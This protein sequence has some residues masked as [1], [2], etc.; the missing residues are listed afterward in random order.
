MQIDTITHHLPLIT[1]HVF[2]GGFYVL[3]CFCLTFS[4]IGLV[5]ISKYTRG[6]KHPALSHLKDIVFILFELYGVQAC[7]HVLAVQANSLISSKVDTVGSATFDS[8][9]HITHIY[10]PNL[11]S[12]LD[13][14]IFSI[15]GCTVVILVL[16]VHILE[17]YWT[18]V[19]E[20]RTSPFGGLVGSKVR[21]GCAAIWNGV[22][23]LRLGF[24]PSS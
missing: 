6:D 19:N 1:D 10:L 13:E 21:A 24:K 12:I 9:H 3:M 11:F 23:R 7:W 2:D 14:K 22:R 15:I 17:L 8:N 20:I 4:Y 18:R 16:A 5:L